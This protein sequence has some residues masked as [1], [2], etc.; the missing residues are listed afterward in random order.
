MGT[1]LSADEIRKIFREELEDFKDELLEELAVLSQNV[2]PEDPPVTTA[3]VCRRWGR[4][5][6]TLSKLIRS[7][8]LAPIGKYKHS[9]TFRASDIVRLFGMP[10]G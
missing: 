3:E 7:Q 1:E 10:V 2:P 6:T 4:S 5:R 8:K 9:F